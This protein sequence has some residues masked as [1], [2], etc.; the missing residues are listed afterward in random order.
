MRSWK[1]EGSGVELTEKGC[2]CGV[3]ASCLEGGL[4]CCDA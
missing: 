4:D 1:V 3:D 2:L